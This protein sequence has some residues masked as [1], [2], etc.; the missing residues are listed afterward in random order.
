MKKPLPTCSNSQCSLLLPFVV[1]VISAVSKRTYKLP[2]VVSYL[3]RGN[4][5]AFI[6]MKRV[7][8]TTGLNLRQEYYLYMIADIHH[9]MR[10]GKEG[11]AK[12]LTHTNHVVFRNQSRGFYVPFDFR[13]S[14]K[15][16]LFRGNWTAFIVVKRVVMTTG[17]NLRQVYHHHGY[18]CGCR[19]LAWE[20]GRKG[21][22]PSV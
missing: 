19:S 17:L 20:A 11:L 4:S 10:G 5:T 1:W 16:Y 2:V 3:F 6:V 9:H 7:V 18:D 12:G 13:V 15:S 8:M 22:P 14:L 21:S